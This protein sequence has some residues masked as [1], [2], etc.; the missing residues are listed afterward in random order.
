MNSG[1]KISST[2]TPGE[3]YDETYPT[4]MAPF[5]RSDVLDPCNAKLDAIML[6]EKTMPYNSTHYL[7]SFKFIKCC[8]F[9]CSITNYNEICYRKC[10]KT[11]IIC[12]RSLAQ[13]VCV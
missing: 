7:S 1:K 13:D 4:T 2:T 5:P 9:A 3:I 6:G 12:L 11:V 10:S 8:R